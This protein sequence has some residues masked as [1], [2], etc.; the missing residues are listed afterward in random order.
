MSL[1]E[2]KYFLNEAEANCSY[3]TQGEVNET[4]L[5]DNT[6][7]IGPYTKDQFTYIDRYLSLIHI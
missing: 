1:E 5:D 3:A 4:V 6:I 7:V 2:I